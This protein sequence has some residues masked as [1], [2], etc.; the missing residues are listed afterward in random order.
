MAPNR[1]TLLHASTLVAARLLVTVAVL[2]LG[3]EALSD[4]DFARVTLAQQFAEAPQLDPTGTSWLPF[5]FWLNGS[6]MA[7]FGR[8]LGVARAVTVLI[9]C[10]FSLL[11]YASA[12]MSRVPP[13]AA[14]LGVLIWTFVPVGVFAGASTVPELSTAALCASSLL[15]LRRSD[16]RASL[17]AAALVLPATLSRY[18]AWPIALFVAISIGIPPKDARRSGLSKASMAGRFGAVVLALLGPIA[19]ISWNWHAHGDPMHFHARVS[20]YWFAWGGGTQP[21]WDMLAA[22]PK[23][24]IFGAPVLVASAVG[25]VYWTQHREHLRSWLRPALGALVMLVALTLAQ[26]TGGAPTHHPERTLLLVWAIGWI[27]TAD[28][29]AGEFARRG[30]GWD[31]WRRAWLAGVIVFMLVR[32]HALTPWYGVRRSE[33]VQL[34]RWLGENTHGPVLLAPIDFGYFAVM[35]G[36][37]DPDRVML[38]SSV[39]PR[40]ATAPSPFEDEARLRERIARDSVQWLAATGEQARVAERMGDKRFGLGPWSVVS[41]K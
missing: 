14:W 26:S 15:L 27:A 1:T 32:T 34:G 4:D 5:P 9:A 31:L 30:R 33:E 38:A 7:A 39:D 22:Y 28:L 37:G 24:V 23:T 12:R 6:L 16:L 29:L 19:W 11:L 20:A 21:P 36:M 13:T 10:A 25:A 40:A 18:E 35:A 41:V 3:F 17:V 2:W 8:S